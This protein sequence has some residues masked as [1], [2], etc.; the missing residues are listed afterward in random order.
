MKID[1]ELWSMNE[2]QLKAESD[3]YYVYNRR[4]DIMINCKKT[5]IK[6]KVE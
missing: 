2:E 5:N 4:I 6:F 1:K 3:K